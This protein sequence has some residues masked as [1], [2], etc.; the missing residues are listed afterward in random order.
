MSI[1]TKTTA[2]LSIAAVSMIAGSANA[3]LFGDTIIADI[4][5]DGGVV[6][7]NMETVLDGPEGTGNWLGLV[8][9]DVQSDTISVFSLIEDPAFSWNAGLSVNFSDLNFSS[10]N[11][12]IG[13]EIIAAGGNGMSDLTMADLSWTDDSLSIDLGAL[14][15]FDARLAQ[16]VTVRLLT[17]PAPSAL[18][19]LG[20]GA[21][22][23][24]RRR[25]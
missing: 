5:V 15:G 22:P 18:S 12:I 25:R 10:G 23:M 24:M 17:V 1:Y 4:L 3:S 8:G 13:A 20:L 11:T 2:A 7:S 19:L 16:T 14:T 9:Y 6:S 21:V